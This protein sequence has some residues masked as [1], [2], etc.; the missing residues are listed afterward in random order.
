V[1]TARRERVL[2]VAPDRLGPE[3]LEPA[4]RVVE[5]LPDQPLQP[6][7][8]ALA[9]GAEALPLQVPPDDAGR[10]EHRA[11]DPGSL[12][13]HPGLVPELAEPHGG[14]EPRHPGASD[15]DPHGWALLR[16]RD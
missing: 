1:A 10:E 4:E 6:L 5:P 15:G 8:A 7:V 2:G 9:L 12:L 11:A 13:Q 16:E 3:R 14:D